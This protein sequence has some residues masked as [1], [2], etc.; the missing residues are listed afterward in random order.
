MRQSALF[1]P[2][3]IG[4]MSMKNRIV[5]PPMCQYQAKDG[6]PTTWHHVHYGKLAGSGAGLVC[7]E[8]VGVCAEGRI[9][10]GDLGLWN[11]EQTSAFAELI[12]TMRAIDPEV[13]V[14]VQ[15]SHSGRKGSHDLQ[16]IGR[17]LSPQEGGWTVKAPS[18]IGAGGDYPIPEAMTEEEIDAVV[19][20]Y[21]QAAARAQQAGVDSIQ[22]HAAHGYL[23]HQFLSP[24][25]NQRDDEYGGC[26]E[27]RM[28]MPIRVFETMRKAAPNVVLGVR[29]SATDWIEGGWNEHDTVTF[30][31]ALK[32]FG[33][34]FV[35]VS[36]G[37]LSED[38]RLEVAYGYQLKYARIIKDGCKL[39]TFGVGLV[40]N[41]YQAESAIVEGACDAIGVGRAMLLDPH[42]GWRAAL[43]LG[44]Q[45][46]FPPSYRRG[47]YL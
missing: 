11:D 2:L 1:T 38:Q 8:S 31:N 41:A 13:K 19:E 25:S 40:K 36:S 30:V 39:P 17:L 47:M 10:I 14:M 26:L 43:E 27:N 16:W 29:V 7:I 35:D 32:S 45:V 12:K 5:V 6:L 18:A 9:T 24:I 15:L 46:Q 33:C 20:A 44:V 34:E 22:L 37:G 3:Q 21:A 42:W 4:A 28:R 23:V